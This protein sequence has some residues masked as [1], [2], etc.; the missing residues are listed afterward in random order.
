MT[1]LPKLAAA[2][3]KS[4]RQQNLI[5]EQST[6]LAAVSG[7][8]DSMALLHLLHTLRLRLKI[9]LHAATFDHGL[10]GAASAAD[11]AHVQ[12]TGAAWDIPVMVGQVA[13]DPAASGIE[14]R[15]RAARYAFL[16]QTAQRVGA[17]L[18]ATGHHADDQAET[19]LLHLIRGG[20]LHG[21][22]G[23]RPQTP[24]PLPGFD[25]LSLIR[26]LLGVTR[27]EIEQ[28]CAEQ[29]IAYRHDATNDTPD[30]L[31]NR[32]RLE[33]LPYLAQFNPRIIEA[34]N[35][36]AEIASLE[37]T[38]IQDAMHQ[39]TKEAELETA[40]AIILPRNIYANLPAAL[41]LRWLADAATRLRDPERDS[42]KTAGWLHLKNADAVMMTGAVGAVAQLPGFVQV[43]LSSTQISVELAVQEEAK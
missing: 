15:A 26:P 42:D 35:R 6:V 23:L 22:G 28:Y 25:S 24:Y 20:G 14:A 34:L 11:A 37:D 43:R 9:D 21:L 4:I 1:R 12:E 7:G 41:R 19:V 36:F 40:H 3:L 33:A 38:Y 17:A 16:A 31:R 32:L 29:Q 39:Q 13:L 18:V 2:L 27:Q 8:A 10:R 5:P 30:T